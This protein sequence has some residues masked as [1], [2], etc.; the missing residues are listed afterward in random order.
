VRA[1]YP[2]AQLATQSTLAVSPYRERGADLRVKW[3]F[4]GASTLTGR[5]GYVQRRNDLATFPDFAG[6]AYDM[7]YLWQPTARSS[8]TVLV[9]RQTGATG[10]NQYLSSVAHT[11]RLSPTYAATAKIQVQAQFELSQFDYLPIAS[12]PTR[13]DSVHSAGLGATWVPRR[14]ITVKIAQTWEQRASSLAVFDYLDRVS[15]LSLQATF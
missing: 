2:D 7:T 6:A 1:T 12:A 15:S 5:V 4:S 3:K 11:Y 13:S 9:L 8:L 10:D 14:W